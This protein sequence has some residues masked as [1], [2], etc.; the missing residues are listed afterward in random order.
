MVLSP[1]MGMAEGGAGE[2]ARASSPSRICGQDQG[3]VFL[4]FKSN[5][6]PTSTWPSCH[7]GLT[8]ATP[9][10]TVRVGPAVTRA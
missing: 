6:P 10:L 8:K 7:L 9:S 1:M 2:K 3:R 4:A 5:P